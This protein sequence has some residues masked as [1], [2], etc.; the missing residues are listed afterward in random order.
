MYTFLKC[1]DHETKTLPRLTLSTE[2][3]FF[4]SSARFLQAVVTYKAAKK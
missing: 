4:S 3:V 2:F 1:T